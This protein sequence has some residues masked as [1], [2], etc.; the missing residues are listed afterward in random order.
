M[1]IEWDVGGF[2]QS[3]VLPS[4]NDNSYN[5]HFDSICFPASLT[6][7][8]E[9]TRSRKKALKGSKEE[10]KKKRINENIM[11]KGRSEGSKKQVN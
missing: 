9:Q 3:P 6:L 10:W 4:S 2:P 11:K 7:T 8:Y 5:A 1:R